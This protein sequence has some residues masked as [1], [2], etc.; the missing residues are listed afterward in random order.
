MILPVAVPAHL[1]GRYPIFF[2]VVLLMGVSALSFVVLQPFLSAIAW[3]IVL[4]VAVRPVW[5]RVERRFSKHRSVAAATTSLLVAL[6]VLLPAGLLGVALATQAAQAASR[7][8]V[9]LRGR[10]VSKVSDLGTLP[11]VGRVLDWLQTNAGLT[12]A[13]M[14]QH[15]ADLAARASALVAAKGGGIVVGFFGAVG[16]FL[17]AMF[18]LFFFLR[19]GEAMAE[20][21]SEL[22]PLSAGER[23]MAMRRLGSMLE[24]IFKGALLTAL[25]QGALGGLGWGLA[26][27]PSPYLAGAAM[28]VL[29]LLPIGGTAFVWLPGAAALAIEGRTGAAIFLFAWGAAAVGM[30]DNFLKPLLIK[31]GGELNTLVVFLGVFGGLM[32]FG[33]LGVF[34]GPIVLATAQT[35][36]DVLRGLAKDAVREPSAVGEPPP[37]S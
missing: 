35:L 30:V 26:G 14:R 34:I 37:G 10:D 12:P 5:V 19:D 36:L 28:A 32:A 29:S 4:S 31:G 33:L 9:F 27:L 20:A 21:L 17:L 15:A 1:T 2:F 11:V 24:S 23:K 25:V 22:L 13:S 18:L 3:A 6:V 8:V 7:C 16:M